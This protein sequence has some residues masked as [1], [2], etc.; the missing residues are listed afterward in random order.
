MTPAPPT[1]LPALPIVDIKKANSKG[2]DKGKTSK[3]STP[4]KPL[5]LSITGQ[6]EPACS[7][8]SK[9]IAATVVEQSS[10]L[11]KG[12]NTENDPIS[13]ADTIPHNGTP[14]M[15]LCF[16]QSSSISAAEPNTDAIHKNG[17]CFNQ[18]NSTPMQVP[19]LEDLAMLFVK[20]RYPELDL[21][22]LCNTY[23]KDRSEMQTPQ[24][25][26]QKNGTTSTTNTRFYRDMCT[27]PLCQKILL[28]KHN[29]LE[30]EKLLV[31]HN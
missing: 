22:A 9:P 25:L 8:D 23:I 1:S 10:P 21:Y 20:T 12:Q 5:D 14:S 19:S 27:E 28:Q 31:K 18:S 11:L 24:A 15:S 16:N 3:K 4:V 17:M 7:T 30:I 6:P 13:S 29:E 2:K 26:S